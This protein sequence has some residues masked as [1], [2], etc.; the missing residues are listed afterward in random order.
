M[1]MPDLQICTVGGGPDKSANA[2]HNDQGLNQ[3]FAHAA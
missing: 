1:R 2:V 3:I